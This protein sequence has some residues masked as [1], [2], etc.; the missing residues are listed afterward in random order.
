MQPFLVVDFLGQTAHPAASC[1]A[2][3]ALFNLGLAVKNTIFEEGPAECGL[4]DIDDS[5][6]RAITYPI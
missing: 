3:K 5:Q 6:E 1:G 2:C 4:K